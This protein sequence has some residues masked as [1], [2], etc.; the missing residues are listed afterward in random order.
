MKNHYHLNALQISQERFKLVNMDSPTGKAGLTGCHG[1]TLLELLLA[2]VIAALVVAIVSVA[3][4][5]SLRMWQHQQ[6]ADKESGIPRIIALMKWQLACF[7][8][9]T[10]S[11]E[12]KSK[13]IFVGTQHALSL[14]TDYSLKALSKG[15]PVIARY[16]YNP[17]EKT[18]YYAEIP[19]DP[20]HPDTVQ[21][22]LH[23]NPDR[24]TSWPHFY[25]IKISDF[26]LSYQGKDNPKLTERWNSDT[27][28]PQAIQLKWSDAGKDVITQDIVPGCLFPI[29][30]D[31]SGTNNQSES[32][33]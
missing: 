31:T 23:M 9:Q 6:G 10:I 25:S 26:S 17:E 33:K 7:D 1:F 32:G 15:V 4:T 14:A 19:M 27:E 2:T 20:Y 22:F 29:A 8:P 18:L 3:L 13:T 28:I 16:I 30:T 21:N 5:F 24:N 11:F 12:G